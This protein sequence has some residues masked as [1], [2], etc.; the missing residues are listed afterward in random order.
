MTGSFTR[1]RTLK[2]LG[3]RLRRFVTPSSVRNGLAFRARPSDIIISPYSKCG[4]TW[5]QQ[6][7]HGLR[8]KG[9]MSFEE[10]TA[11]V[12][13]IE[14]AEDMGIPLDATQPGHVR[15]FKSHLPWEKVPK[16]CRYIYIIRDPKDVAVSAYHFLEGWFFERGT[17]SLREFILGQHLEGPP[18]LSYWAHIRSWWPHRHNP[19]VLFLAYEA[20]REHLERTV[21]RVAKFLGSELDE[22]EF[23]LII[24][25]SSFE[26]MK[27]HAEQ[28]DDHI[29]R[30]RRDAECGLP[31]GGDSSK[32]RRGEI[33]GHAEEMTPEIDDAMEMRWKQEMHDTLGFR[34]YSEMAWALETE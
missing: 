11:V 2:E 23:E 28:F 8:T 32:V 30:S 16:G 21:V 31:P 15:L 27:R 10:I 18:E 9:D 1:A 14:L 6:I 4:T 33:G 3:L 12:P 25:Q 34:S 19:K 13:W 5:M 20:M 22:E 24:E 29:L 17:I 7:T 26:F